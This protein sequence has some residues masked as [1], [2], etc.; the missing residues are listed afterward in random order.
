MTKKKLDD[1]YEIKNSISLEKY[2]HLLRAL[3]YKKYKPYIKVNK[4]KIFNLSRRI[5]NTNIK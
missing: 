3:E 5:K 1:L 4:K 2:K